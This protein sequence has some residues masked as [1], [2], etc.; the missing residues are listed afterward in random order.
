[1]RGGF[2]F[3]QK[4]TRMNFFSCLPS[5]VSAAA[6]LLGCL[7]LLSGCQ[8]LDIFT[9][10]IN[11]IDD[12]VSEYRVTRDI[13]Y[14][15][16]KNVTFDL[17]QPVSIG[18]NPA[19]VVI[20]IHGGGWISGDKVFLSPTIDRLTKIKKNLAIVNINYRVKPASNAEDLFTTQLTDLQSVIDFIQYNAERY[21]LRTD[22]Y[23]L[24]GASAGGHLALAYAY[25]NRN[26]AVKAV[27]A[28]SAPTELS[29]RELLSTS[30]WPNVEKLIGRRYTDSTDAFRKGSPFHLATYNCPKTVLVY[31]QKDTL[32][33]NQQGDIMAKK[34][35]LLRVPCQFQVFPD[36]GHDISPELFAE[37]ILA[38]YN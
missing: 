27:V 10:E 37:S 4:S 6:S 1:M 13:L 21:N 33:S 28:I 34:L 17:H 15:R 38:T 24:A 31:G 25:K 9:P 14:G 19:E 7:L 36:E 20:L 22:G 29:I 5:R 35:R 26:N 30:L 3:G 23:R 12:P 8:F 16:D 2:I 18:G 32:V 11:Y